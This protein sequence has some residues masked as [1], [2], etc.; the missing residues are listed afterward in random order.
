MRPN[1]IYNTSDIGYM[2]EEWTIYEPKKVES[3]ESENKEINN[4]EQVEEV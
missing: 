1:Y 2:D 3:I 4:E